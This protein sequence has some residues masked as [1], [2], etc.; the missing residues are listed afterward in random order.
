MFAHK[1]PSFTLGFAG[2][3]AHSPTP[4][5]DSGFPQQNSL[6]LLTMPTTCT[7]IPYALEERLYSPGFEN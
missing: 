1:M 6:R 5:S 3:H 4:A 2:K 7:M